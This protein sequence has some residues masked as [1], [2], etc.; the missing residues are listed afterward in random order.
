MGDL[1]LCL[2]VCLSR[3][4]ALEGSFCSILLT[5][6]KLWGEKPQKEICTPSPAMSTKKRI[7]LQALE[8]YKK[9]NLLLVK[10]QMRAW[11]RSLKPRTPGP[12]ETSSDKGHKTPPKTDSRAL[13]QCSPRGGHPYRPSFTTQ[14]FFFF[15]L[16]SELC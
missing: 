2:S 12:Q 1:S 11:R 8:N 15:F 13:G 14:P 9:K 4:P 3:E 7:T 5:L 10:M 6:W 16:V